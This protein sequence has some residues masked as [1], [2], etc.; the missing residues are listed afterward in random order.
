MAI[1]IAICKV[2]KTTAERPILFST[3]MVIAIRAGKK[4]ATRRLVNP[5]PI[6]IVAAACAKARFAAGDRLWVRETWR[7]LHPTPEHSYQRCVNYRA[8]DQI[9]EISR[10]VPYEDWHAAHREE[11]H[12]EN[13]R[14]SIFMPRWA[15]R[16]T[17]EVL[18]VRVERLHE[19]TEEDARAEGIRE[20]DLQ[21]G[22]PGAWW[23]ADSTDPYL[24]DRTPRQA[25]GR[26]W[27]SINGK[28]DPWASNPWVWR[29]EFRVLP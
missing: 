22:Q 7:T 20:L 16:I 21:A 9:L 17:L 5:Q 6:G 14:P 23:S 19:I 15:S 25:F 26:L 3:P 12:L 28:R 4:S 2:T 29:V 13:W 1:A 24:H 8:D 11:K 10:D 18:S 27:D